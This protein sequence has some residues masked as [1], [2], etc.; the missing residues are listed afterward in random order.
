MNVTLKEFPNDLHARLKSL[1]EANGRSLN[2]Q[3]I[4]TLE[5]VTSPRK[6]DD[7]ELLSRI[8]INRESIVGR[9][10]QKFLDEAI[11]DRRP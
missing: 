7:S 4:H 1:A 5:A 3:I 2:R 10:D 9:I 6:T 11:D 8:K